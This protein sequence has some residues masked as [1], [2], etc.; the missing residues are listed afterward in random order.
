MKVSTEIYT[1]YRKN[2]EALL[3]QR[4]VDALSK[5]RELSMFITGYLIHMYMERY[6]PQSCY[7]K[8]IEN[9]PLVDDE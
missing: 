3:T 2:V 6:T 9:F 5:D 4:Y 7:L 8:I 1:A